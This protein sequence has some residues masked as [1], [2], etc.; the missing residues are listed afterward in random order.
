MELP[1]YRM[2]TGKSIMIHM[3]EK[4]AKQYLHKMGG[5]LDRFYHH[6][7]LGYF[8]RHSENGD[9]FEK[10]IAEVEQSDT[11][12]E[13]K[14]ETIAELERLKS[15]D[16]QQKSYI[17]RIGQAI[18]PILHPLGF[19]WKMSVSL[20]TGMAAKEVVV[21]TLSVLYTGESDDSQVLTE[22]LKQDKKCRGRIGLYTFGRTEFHALCPDL[23]PLY[24]YNIG[25]CPRIRLLEMGVYL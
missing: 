3:W 9:V 16:H 18:Q 21:S 24:R 17:G 8:P 11:N 7:F 5:H 19:D 10:Q 2:P 25:H 15:M 23:F 13:D 1:P 6:P 12:P 20:L 22:R 4:K 14:A